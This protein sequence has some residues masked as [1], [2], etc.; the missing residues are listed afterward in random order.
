MPRSRRQRA[1]SGPS[2]NVVPLQNRHAL[3][4]KK[5]SYKVVFEEMTGRKK[6]KTVVS[7]QSHIDKVSLIK[8][9]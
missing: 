9:F 1:Q 8:D 5:S 6:L 7:L 3:P 2:G 4:E